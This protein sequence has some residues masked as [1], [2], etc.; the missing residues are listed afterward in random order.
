MEQATEKLMV[1]HIV[2]KFIAS[3]KLKVHFRVHDSP[4]MAPY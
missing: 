4:P 1:T 2:K 3:L